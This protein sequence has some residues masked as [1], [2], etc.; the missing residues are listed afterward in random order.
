MKWKRPFW[1]GDRLF[2]QEDLDLIFWTVEQY[3]DLSRTELAYTICENLDWRAPNGKERLHSCLELL[4]KLAAD[5]MLELPEKRKLSPYKKAGPRAAPLPKI[6]IKS[7]LRALQPVTVDPVPP[8]EQSLWDATMAAHHPFEFKRAFGAHQRYWIY[9]HVDGNKLVVG[10]FLFAAPARNVAVRDAWLGWTQQE[11]QRFRH[12][13]VSNSRML[14]LPGVHV[15]H[16]ASHALS[17]ALRR[18]PQDWQAR[19][20]Y[21]PVMVETFVTPPWP[22]TC[23]RAANWIHLGQTAGSGR[24]DRKYQDEATVREVFVYPLQRGW[25]QALTAPSQGP[26]E[27]GEETMILSEPLM[28]DQNEA[29][30]KQKYDMLAPF[31]D[32]KQRRLFAGT[33]A[34]SY[35]TGGLKRIAA[36]LE[37]STA[38]VSRGMKEVQNPKTIV[39]EGIRKSGGGR[40]PATATD[41]DLLHDLEQLI[42]P[43]TRGDP[44]SPLRWTCKSTRKLTAELQAMKPG[45]SVSP[46]L[47]SK[48][49]REMGY[50]LQGNRKTLEGTEHPDRDA[51]FQHINA[52]VTEY[53]QREQPVISVD[54]K[55][56]E[57]VGDFKNAGA[58][59]QPKG[60]PEEVRTYDF[61]LPDLGKV[62]P[63]GVYDRTRNEGW[64]NVGTDRD[65]ASFAVASIRGW[66]Q[67]MGREAYPNATELLITADGGGS[68]GSRSRLWKVEVQNFADETGLCIA[69]CH[70]PPGTSKWNAI[71]HRMFSHIT[72][73]WRG[74][75]LI[76]H[77]TIVN[78]IANTTTKSG[79]TIQ[80]QLDTQS[81]PKGIKISD[82]ELATVDLERY[83]FHGE[84][85]YTIRPSN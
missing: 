34:I 79:L 81:Y 69:V 19:Y 38:T 85:N 2:S 26:S 77:E 30:I 54:T 66:W 12:R 24:Q 84:W 56:K 31:L 48:L 33:E 20:G 45:R 8:E 36:V 59:W 39:S 67:Q 83:D 73:N 62:S 63:Y 41:P 64:V 74:R 27:K 7:P 3:A 47:V 29:C 10:A 6:P 51:Q 42:A 18:L 17:K 78:L 58:E 72:Q 65:T 52:M 53:Q 11:Q 55:K 22:G 57:L 60:Q 82:K 35:G 70:Y 16:L 80:C 75:P 21:S 5:G 1:I 14:I 68:N 76:S 23:Y 25:R 40:K 28:S 71:E 61:P 46:T 44:Q 32:E 50:S 15:P 9:G 43:E 37:M 49:L 13:I 4:E